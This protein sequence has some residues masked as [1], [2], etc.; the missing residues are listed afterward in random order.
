[1]RYLYRSYCLKEGQG[2][3]KGSQ[4]EELTIKNKKV[5]REVLGT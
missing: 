1:M 3:F 2:Q 5:A 4:M